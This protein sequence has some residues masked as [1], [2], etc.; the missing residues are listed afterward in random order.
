MRQRKDIPAELKWD[1]THLFADREAWE[2]ECSECEKMIET[3][4]TLKGTL[5]VSSKSLYEA[6]EKLYEIDEKF[7]K[8][9]DY[10]FFARV[11]DGGD[12]AALEM[13][14]RVRNVGVK[15]GM[16]TS[17]MEPELMAIP[18]ERLAE[19]LRD[20]K[21]SAKYGHIIEDATR[22]R[23]HVL[24]EK[25][26]SIIARFRKITD[27][28]NDI[29]KTFTNVEL[30]FPP[31]KDENGED[32]ELTAG[33]FGSFR[34]SRDKNVRDS[35]FK[36]MFGTYGK[37]TNTFAAIYGNSVKK[38]N[39][40]AA[41]RGFGSARAASLARSNVPETVYDS[42]I[43]AVRGAIPSMDKYLELR[44]KVMG[45]DKID[46]YD[47]YTP[48]VPDVD[49]PMTYE[50]AKKLVLGATAPLGKDYT[51][52]IRRAFDE[53][54]VDVYETPGKESGAFS[55]GVYGVHPFVK[56]NFA[57]TLDDAFTL[58][59]ELG[60]SMHSYLSSK[61]QDYANHNYSLLV[62]E[63]A[64][65]CNEVL[66]TK[67]LLSTEKD[68]A[69]KAYILN[70]FLEGFRTT[71]FRQTLFAEF[72]YQ[73]HKMEQEG[74]PLTSQALC[75]LYG[76]LE[77]TYYR[78]AEFR[79]EIRYEWSYIPHFY[80]PFYVYQYATGFSS[81][82][83]IATHILETGDASDYL[84]FLSTGGSDYPINELKIAGVDLTTPAVVENAMTVFDETIDE[85]A[86]LLLK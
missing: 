71:I 70:H 69:R 33:T 42:L 25:S 23:D 64:S 58:A 39:L 55:A 32:R 4:P 54:W 26:E 35:A 24:D 48:M 68:P 31:V 36:A 11:I 57:S 44:R 37:Y 15:F 21:L 61:T 83:A 52:V 65:T 84:R 59:H 9:A 78:N 66:L 19:F 85:L 27:T 1:F 6:Y 50:N 73:A 16:N 29:F 28:A 45:L 49:Y 67:Y 3:L 81:A 43:K 56:L 41:L 76:D 53:N 5:G 75:D 80:R 2:K 7:S 46:V 12:T 82:V 62:A 74:T 51:E 18:E 60:H 20:E 63:V 86:G 13:T 17:F 22:L 14:D 38:D 34:E 8:V 77:K 40:M 10:A 30:K 47:L 72:E 79:E